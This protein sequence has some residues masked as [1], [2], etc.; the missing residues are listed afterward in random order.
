LNEGVMKAEELD[1]RLMHLEKTLTQLQDLEAIKSLHRE[2]VFQMI[3]HQWEDMAECFSDNGTAMIAEHPP[4]T[5]RKEIA[6]LLKEVI[7]PKLAWDLGHFVNQ[8]VITVQ[9]NTARGQ[10]AS[11]PAHPGTGQQMGTGQ[12]RL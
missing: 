4:R 2:Y 3:N 10:L 7:G 1:A 12:I 8:T 5:G 6:Q 9:D 11:F